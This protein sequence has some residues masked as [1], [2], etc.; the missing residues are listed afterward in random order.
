MTVTSRS[1]LTGFG[2]ALA[3]AVAFAFSGT[4]AKGL[5]ETG[6]SS[7]AAIL[8]RIGGAALVLLI[9][10]IVMLVRRWPTVRGELPR[11]A[12]YGVV[13]IALCQLFFFNAVQHL[14][15]GV[16]LLLEY[17]SPVLLVLF[18]WAQSRKRPQVLVLAGAISAVAGL[19][20]VLDLSGTQSV[21]LMGVLWG[22]AAA[23]CSAFYFVMSARAVDG[24]PPVLMIGGGLVV[25]AV[26]ILVLGVLGVMPMTFSTQNVVFAGQSMSW[27]VPVLGLALVGTV[28][29]YTTGVLSVRRLG[30]RVASFVSLMEVLFAVVWA[31]LLLSELPHPIQLLGGALIML[32][33]I[34]VR[35]GEQRSASSPEISELELKVPERVPVG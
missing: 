35:M 34:L 32:G 21:D 1:S 28:F 11:I 8:G 29:A 22:L 12:L 5:F 3:S 26:L 7:G 13:P 33:V 20:L 15:V 19:L 27:L 6:W 23:V 18:S 24:V 30:T 14:S 17:L 10:V 4:F 25:G 16:A 31:W 9:P 2:F